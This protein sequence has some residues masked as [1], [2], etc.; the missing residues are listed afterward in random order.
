MADRYVP[1][2]HEALQHVTPALHRAWES[3]REWW[4]PR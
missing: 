4:S 1:Q 2:A 3:V